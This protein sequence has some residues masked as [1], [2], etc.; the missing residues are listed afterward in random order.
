M[1]KFRNVTKKV[2]AFSLCGIMMLG[3]AACGAKASNDMAYDSYAPSTESA[4]GAWNNGMSFDGVIAEDA[5]DMKAEYEMSDSAKVESPI[6]STGSGKEDSLVSTTTRKVIKTANLNLQTLDF[7]EFQAALD[8]KIAEA[9]AYLQYADVSGSDYYGG[10][11]SGNYTVRVPEANLDFF[12]AD[13]E[14]IATVTSKILGE[15][16]VTLNYVDTEARIKTLQIEQERLLSLLEKADDLDSIIRLEQ[17]L[18]EVRYNIESYQSKLRTYDDKITYS[19]VRI[20]VYEVTRVQEKE[21]ETLWERI[22]NGWAD[23][24]YDISTGA[25]DLLVWA[26]VNLPYLVFWG[27]VIV[28]I[29]IVLKKKSAKRKAKKL[30]KQSEN[31][32]TVLDSKE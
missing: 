6:L 22:S 3:L 24:M 4:G 25:Q 12:L 21:P 17:R 27:A 31:N 8:Q 32:E 26:V 13:V 28:V 23:T 1:R 20:Y 30:G 7:E 9:G 16:D 18:S 15:E 5:Y 14:G 2:A 10:R 19:T 11:K 29:V